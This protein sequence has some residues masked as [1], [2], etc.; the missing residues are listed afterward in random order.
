MNNAHVGGG[1]TLLIVL[2]SY[3]M[4]NACVGEGSQ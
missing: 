1:A 4:N 2:S 3:P